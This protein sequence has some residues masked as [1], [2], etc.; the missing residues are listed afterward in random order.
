MATLKHL[1]TGADVPLAARHIVGRSRTC[2][3]Q[4]DLA[5]VSALHA[6]LTWDGRVWCVRDLGSRNG[7]FVD[8]RRVAAGQRRMLAPGM[9]IGLGVR[10]GHYRFVDEEAPRLIA[11]GPDGSRVAEGDVFCL[12]SPARCEA[13]IFRGADE[14][15]V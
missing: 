7:T 3:L 1:R 9:D 15:W 2:Q 6:E 11:F 5:S 8:G 12:P 4:L 10:E 14:R 13:M